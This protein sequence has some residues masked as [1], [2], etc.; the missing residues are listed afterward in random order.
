MAGEVNFQV[1]FGCESVSTDVAFVGPLPG[2]RSDM[3]L[4]GRV[5]AKHLSAKLASVLKVGVIF[6]HTF[7]VAQVCQAVL[8]EAM[9]GIV[10]DALRLLL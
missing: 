10:Q 5:R 1:S 6:M 8:Q 9:A 7:V 2:V 3:N 4:K